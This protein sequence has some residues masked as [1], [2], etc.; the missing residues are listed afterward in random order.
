MAWQR[1]RRMQLILVLFVSDEHDSGVGKEAIK[2]SSTRFSFSPDD[3]DCGLG[4]VAFPSS[5]TKCC[6]HTVK[7]LWKT[8][9]TAKVF[10]PSLV[11]CCASIVRSVGLFTSKLPLL[12]LLLTNSL[13]LSF[14]SEGVWP[15]SFCSGGS[16]NVLCLTSRSAA[17]AAGTTDA[18]VTEQPREMLLLLLLPF[19]KSSGV[20]GRTH[21][22]AHQAPASE[23]ERGG[24]KA[25]S[26]TRQQRTLG[27]NERT[28][29]RTFTLSLSVIPR[30]FREREK[31]DASFSSPT[32]SSFHSLDSHV[33]GICSLSLSLPC[34]GL[35]LLFC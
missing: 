8:C 31:G 22:Q 21:T 15:R 34:R 16:S 1:T 20:R 13:S 14:F 23:A 19:R 25:A 27:K 7:S 24:G 4:T 12:L 29:K 9:Q 26:V 33:R 3:F 5:D 18:R 2:F 28:R 35:F 10:R 6:S 11:R 17:A 32:P 30:A